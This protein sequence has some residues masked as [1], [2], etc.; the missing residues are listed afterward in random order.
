MR[1]FIPVNRDFGFEYQSTDSTP[2]NLLCFQEV[3]GGS[4]SKV[5]GP[6][7]PDVHGQIVGH[8][9]VEPERGRHLTVVE[10]G[11]RSK[12]EVFTENG[13]DSDVYKLGIKCHSVFISPGFAFN[14]PL[15]VPD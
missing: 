14:L 4:R 11:S 12:I 10:F 9:A 6:E 1:V 13:S 7:R 5:N 3:K 15:G 8:L 2:S